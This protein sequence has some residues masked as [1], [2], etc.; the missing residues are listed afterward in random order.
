MASSWLTPAQTMKTVGEKHPSKLLT[1][2]ESFLSLIPTCHFMTTSVNCALGT[3][4]GDTDI[5]TLNHTDN[6]ITL[7]KSIS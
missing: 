1:L 3:Q 2:C 6:L 5:S 7:S 4:L